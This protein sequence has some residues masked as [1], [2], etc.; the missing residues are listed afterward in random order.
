M[1][2]GTQRYPPPMHHFSVYSITKYYFPQDTQ[3][4]LL[5]Y[6][7]IYIKMKETFISH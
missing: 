3:W 7:S 5:L 4:I 6:S 1:L 2:N